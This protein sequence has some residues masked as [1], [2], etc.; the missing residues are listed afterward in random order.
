VNHIRTNGQVLFQLLQFG[1]FADGCFTGGPAFPAELAGDLR[2]CWW[3]CDFGWSQ[4]SRSASKAGKLD[5]SSSTS[6]DW[7]VE[8]EQ[9]QRIGGGYEAVKFRFLLFL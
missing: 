2:V 6:Q 9:C 5:Q 7:T 1:P 3:R 8:D 4:S